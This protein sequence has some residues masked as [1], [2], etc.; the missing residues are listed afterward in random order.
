MGTRCGITGGV[1]NCF[2]TIEWGYR[3]DTCMNNANDC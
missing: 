3:E 2:T 1:C